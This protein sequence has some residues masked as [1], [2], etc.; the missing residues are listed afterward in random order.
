[1]LSAKKIILG[2][3][4]S[5][6]VYLD[7]EVEQRRWRSRRWIRRRWRRGCGGTR[8]WRRGSVGVGGGGV[9][10]GGEEVEQRR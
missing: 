3:Y 5:R 2:N 10:D 6:V 7:L 1:M 8:M 4:L 9:G